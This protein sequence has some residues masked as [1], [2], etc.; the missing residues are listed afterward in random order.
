M[1]LKNTKSASSLRLVVAIGPIPLI[2]E[3]SAYSHTTLNRTHRKH[4]PRRIDAQQ[5]AADL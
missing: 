1:G 2:A 5:S 4:Q 3:S